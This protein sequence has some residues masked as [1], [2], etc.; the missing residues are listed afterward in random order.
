MFVSFESGLVQLVQSDPTVAS[1][2]TG[3]WLRELPPKTV[4]PAWTW[5]VVTDK[6]NVGLIFTTGQTTRLIQVDCFGDTASDTVN[7]AA[8][9]DNVL[10]G[11]SGVLTDTSPPTVRIQVCYR[12]DLMDEPFD[13]DARN[14]RRMLEYEVVLSPV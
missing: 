3:G 2:S 10:N 5:F 13:P 12:T 9:I 14:F 8:A 1:I 7:L 6:P 11:Y 4:L